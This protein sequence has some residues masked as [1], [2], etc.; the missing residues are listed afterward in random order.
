M[1]TPEMELLLNHEALNESQAQSVMNFLISENSTDEFRAAFLATM[2]IKGVRPEELFGFAKSLRER[3]TVSHL[4]G[5]TDIVGTGGDHL[6]TVNVSTAA[7]IVASAAGVKIGKHGNFASTGIHG[8]ADFL[9]K[10]GYQFAMSPSDI[11]KNVGEKN[12]VFILANRYNE[13]FSKFSAV[14]RKLG[15]SSVL[16]YLGPVTNPLDP[17]IAVIGCTSEEAASI[18]SE[19]LLK[20][21]KSGCIIRS[22]A[23]MDEISPLGPS[24]IITVNSS[25]HESTVYP[26]DFDL[27]GIS[28]EDISSGN[29]EEIFSKTLK[30][31]EGKDAKVMKFIAANAAPALLLNNIGKSLGNSYEIA[32]QTIEDGHAASKIKEIGGGA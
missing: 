23:G 29:P 30:G 5:L 8:S 12:F 18:Y 21:G 10:I 26:E 7:S 27:T 32:L 31:I 25:V 24:K 14:R 19:V 28:L 1:T 11:S 16:N 3:A 22:E 2:F 6:N 4:P 13:H 15:F 9:K 17:E 20:S